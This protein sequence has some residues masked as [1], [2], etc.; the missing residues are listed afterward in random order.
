MR[1]LK[2]NDVECEALT[3]SDDGIEIAITSGDSYSASTPGL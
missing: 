1:G 3:P 2:Y